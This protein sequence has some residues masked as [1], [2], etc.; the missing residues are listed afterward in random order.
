MIN[1][2]RKGNCVIKLI[3]QKHVAFETCKNIKLY[4]DENIHST[5]FQCYW[6]DDLT[7][8][9]F[10]FKVNTKAEVIRVWRTYIE[11]ELDDEGQLVPRG[12]RRRRTSKEDARTLIGSVVCSCA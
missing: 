10:R 11:E 8:V 7:K 5:P 9:C 6:P 12:D 4:Y 1:I 3:D 2:Q